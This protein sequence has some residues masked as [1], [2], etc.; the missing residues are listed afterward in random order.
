MDLSLLCMS[1][2]T[3]CFLLNWCEQHRRSVY[4]DSA[5]LSEE[6]CVVFL[7]GTAQVE[8]NTEFL[9][10]M[11]IREISPSFCGKTKGRFKKNKENYYGSISKHLILLVC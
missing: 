4:R 5:S 6:L 11:L 8:L 9:R 2:H 7:V 3:K 1:G 10:L